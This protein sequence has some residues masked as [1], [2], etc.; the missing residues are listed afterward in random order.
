MR[1]S[2]LLS[3]LLSV[4]FL[5]RL[6]SDSTESSTASQDTAF[7]RS[8]RPHLD[9]DWGVLISGDYLY[10][11]ANQQGLAYG[12]Q[13]PFFNSFTSADKGVIGNP[14]AIQ[15]EYQSGYRLGLDLLVP[16]GGWD[17]AFIW[18]QYGA[19][20]KEKLGKLGQVVW[21]Y[22][23]SDAV[24]AYAAGPV[25]AKWDLR[26]NTC[27]LNLG[28]AFQPMRYLSIKPFIGIRT[29]WIEQLL[30]V[31][32]DS[33]I[34]PTEP[35][36]QPVETYNGNISSKNRNHF[37][38]YGTNLGMDTKWTLGGGFNIL[39]DIA[40]SLLWSD[41]SIA[42]FQKQTFPGSPTYPYA[43]SSTSFHEL[44]SVF[45]M[46]GGLEWETHFYEDKMYLEFHAG[47]EQQIW[48]DQNQ[49]LN[50]VFRHCPGFD[51]TRQGGDLSLYG[52]TI[53]GSIGF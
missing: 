7:L 19:S 44:T 33:L 10:W 15:A 30:T 39:A 50:F 1:K 48:F 14:S 53:G 12:L 28:A 3:C 20:Q 36:V 47:W 2:Y 4:C 49:L 46:F 11:K 42:T 25:R 37:A 8:A 22:W 41:F 31:E 16:H 24:E 26:F 29:A 52:L 21:P 45:A 43:K 38:G 6:W 18:T 32:Y 27:D 51:A 23:I 5:S 9:R 13:T 34:T 17:V 40:G 35:T